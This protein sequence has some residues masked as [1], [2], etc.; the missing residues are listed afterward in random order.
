MREKVLRFGLE[1]GLSGVLAE[2]DVNEA[3]EGAPGVVLLNSG[4]LHHVGPSRLYVRI[5]RRFATERRL[6]QFTCNDCPRWQRCGLPPSA[7]CTHRAAQLDGDEWRERRR[8]PL[9][10]SW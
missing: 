7:A 10:G 4:I 5:A 9:L 6:A 2:P 3:V 1:R 8:A